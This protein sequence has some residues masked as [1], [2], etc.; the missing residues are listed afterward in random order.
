MG[1]FLRSILAA[2]ALSSF[3][4]FVSADLSDD[5]NGGPMD[6]H[7]SYGNLDK[8]DTFCDTQ[9][10][11]GLSVTGIEVWATAWQIKGIQLT[12]SDGTKPP[13]Q[14]QAEGDRH[15]SINWNESDRITRMKLAI[16]YAGDALGLVHVE[17]GSKSL[18]V[19][20]DTGSFD[21]DDITLATGILLGA[22]G[23]AGGF[24]D[25][26]TPLFMGE[27]N[28]KAQITNIVMDDSIDDLNAKQQGMEFLALDS[29]Y[30]QNS[31]PPGG[32]KQGWNFQGKSGKAVSSSLSTTQ[33]T[34]YGLTQSVEI[35]ASVEV[36]EIAKV[37]V[38]STTT[39]KWE[40][41]DATT[42]TAS[43]T[44]TTEL[45][46]DMSNDN[47]APGHAM[48]CTAMTIKGVYDGGYTATVAF[49]VNG[50]SFDMKQHGSFKSIGYLKAWRNCGDVLVSEIP[51]DATVADGISGGSRRRSEGEG[52]AREFFA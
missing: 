24:V 48:N 18:D 28:G 19:R 14:G 30:F 27:H 31:N 4:P 41:A 51:G 33:T 10:R 32:E 46:W 3:I 9:W 47:L 11:N 40:Y 39:G 16:N 36:P 8:P 15:Q 5:C 38:Q 35:S 49:Q 21:G 43:D 34:T 42:T 44:D 52:V 12:Y 25:R 20:S 37:S 17:V 50:Q 26:W 29:V 22:N 6:G 1:P 13:L 7:K 23:V 2:G 45:D